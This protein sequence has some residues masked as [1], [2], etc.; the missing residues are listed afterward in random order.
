LEEKELYDLE[1]VSPELAWNS[2]GVSI[3]GGRGNDVAGK[4]LPRRSFPK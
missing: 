1:E 3:R 4:S 2:C